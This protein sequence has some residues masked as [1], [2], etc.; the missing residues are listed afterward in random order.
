MSTFSLTSLRR[1]AAIVVAILPCLAWA[2]A[3]SASTLSISQT[4]AFVVSG[5]SS[6]FGI[7][8][9]KFDPSL[10]QLT[11]VLLSFSGTASGSISL[12]N[13][14][15]E[16]AITAS[17]PRDRLRL[18]FSGSGAPTMITSLSTALTTNPPMPVTL[19]PEFSETFTLPSP[20]ALVA[21]SGTSLNSW[22]AYFTGLGTVSSSIN[23]SPLLNQSTDGS[24]G[25]EDYSNLQSNGTVTLTY[26][27]TAVPEPPTI[28]LAGLGVVGAV[29]VDRSRRLRRARATGAREELPEAADQA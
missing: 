1:L 11:D 8:W 5:V 16:F 28:M 3:A 15:V 10:G 14:D 4:N 20:Q 22:K 25:V 9:Q 17:N 29:V 18:T 6:P 12:T 19:Q 27:Y 2:P 21:V 13:T 23:Q 7:D 26:V 24:T